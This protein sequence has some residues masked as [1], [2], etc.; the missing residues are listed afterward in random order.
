MSNINIEV[1]NKN[2]TKRT[3]QPKKKKRIRKHGFQS[4]MKSTSGIK[5]LKRRRK[6]GRKSLSVAKR[7]K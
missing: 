2:M 1:K 6:K 4:K 7:V 3:W 5:T